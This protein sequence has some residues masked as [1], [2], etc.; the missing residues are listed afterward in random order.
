MFGFSQTE[1]IL[2]C[3]VV[4]VALAGGIGPA[5]A[6][7]KDLASSFR[8]SPTTPTPPAVPV[9][10][11][12]FERL[13]RLF[14]RALDQWHVERTHSTPPA[15]PVDSPVSPVAAATKTPPA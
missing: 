3:L 5:I 2:A 11:P 10:N 7:L 15:G 4:V 6:K 13:S 9:A 12:E 8:R 14:E 1:L